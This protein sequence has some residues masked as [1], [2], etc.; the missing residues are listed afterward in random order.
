MK[1]KLKR[2]GDGTLTGKTARRHNYKN[3]KALGQRAVDRMVEA[4]AAKPLLKVNFHR[5][6]GGAVNEP[7]F[8]RKSN[9]WTAYDEEMALEDELW[10][11]EQA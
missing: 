9:N 7:K 8:R 3:E 2:N 10:E 6:I 1:L 4:D 5:K 11:E